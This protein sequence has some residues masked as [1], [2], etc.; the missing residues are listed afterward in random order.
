MYI[1]FTLCVVAQLS[2]L[3]FV[4]QIV[5]ALALGGSYSWLLHPFD[6]APPFWDFFFFFEGLLYFPIPQD[7]PGSSFFSLPCPR[8]SHFSRKPVFLLFEIGF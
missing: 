5:L 6:M 8:I 1:Y 4:V 3:Y 2:L 7:A